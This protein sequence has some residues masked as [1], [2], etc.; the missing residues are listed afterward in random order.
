MNLDIKEK[1]EN[2]MLER[3]EIKAKL[4]FEGKTPSRKDVHKKATSALG[5]KP[6]LVIIKKI[7]TRY[8]EQQADITIYKYANKE[9]L[10]KLE[11]EYLRKKHQE[12]KKE[13]EAPAEDK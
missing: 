3:E 12:K 8:G 6:E 7:E 2:K 4:S 5:A 1:N 13:G 9:V 11:P 10:E